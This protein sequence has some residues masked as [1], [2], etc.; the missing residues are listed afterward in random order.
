MEEE[1]GPS[2]N[3]LSFSH[4]IYFDYA[5][6]V[7]TI[8]PELDDVLSFISQDASRPFFLRPSFV[9]YFANLWYTQRDKF[10][11]DYQKLSKQPEKNIQLFARLVVTG[12]AASE[13][14]TA[15]EISPIIDFDGSVVKAEQI[16]NFLT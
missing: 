9:Y 16:R 4:N 10:W 1:S 14:E 7:L 13:Y 6:S 2:N 3:R 12:V 15:D 8:G 5:V 11:N